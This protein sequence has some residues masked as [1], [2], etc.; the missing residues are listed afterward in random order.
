MRPWTQPRHIRIRSTVPHQSTDAQIAL[1]LYKC[2]AVQY[3]AV[4]CS[5]CGAV[6]AAQCR[7]CSAVQCS[8]SILNFNQKDPLWRTALHTDFTAPHRTGHEQRSILKPTNHS[9]L[10]SIS[11]SDGCRGRCH[12]IPTRKHTDCTYLQ[13]MYVLLFSRGLSS[14][15][16]R[17][18]G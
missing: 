16:G 9:A 12:S 1:T 2:I 13:H 18:K 6:G 8:G 4:R 17:R 14:R 7:Q 15:A 11:R 3:G 10:E 5:Q